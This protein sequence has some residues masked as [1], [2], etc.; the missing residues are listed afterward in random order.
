MKDAQRADSHTFVAAE[1]QPHRERLVA[2]LQER[3]AIRSPQVAQAFLRVPREAFVSA[4][5]QRETEPGMVWTLRSVATVE[6]EQWMALV[7]HDEPLITKLDERT[8][9]ISSSSAPSVMARML[10]ALDI[11]PGNRVLEIGTGTGYNAALLTHLTGDPALVTTVELDA[12]LARRAERIVRVIA[13]SVCVQTG[14]GR[15]GEPSRAPYDRIIATASAGYLPRAWYAQLAPGGRLVMD[16]QGKQSASGF[17]VV[18]KSPSGDRARGHFW[19]PA[20]CFMPLIDPTVPAESTR[21]LFQQ[22]CSEEITLEPASPLPAIFRDPAF[23]WFLQWFSPT[24]TVTQPFPVP[25][26]DHKAIVLKDEAHATIL[27]LT[28]RA[29]GGWQGKQRGTH[30]LWTQVQQA[31]AHFLQHH[32]PEQERYEV[33]LDEQQAQLLIPGEDETHPF[34][35]C[36]LYR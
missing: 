34:V 8:W 27:Q 35:L 1:S 2:L 29:D 31:Y 7:Y 16:L 28:Q 13:G 20:L 36:D 3:G 9:P 22:P 18:E 12:T 5:Y 11:Q 21:A 19:Q 15:V 26:Q 32:Q 4:F 25:G 30:P 10:E 6:P 17:L 23:R 33:R 14:D 24:L